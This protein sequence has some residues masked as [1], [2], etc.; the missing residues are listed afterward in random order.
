MRPT[1]SDRPTASGRRPDDVPWDI[2]CLPMPPETR[3]RLFERAALSAAD[4]G[5]VLRVTAGRILA[6]HDEQETARLGRPAVRAWACCADPLPA[7]DL[8]A[9]SAALVERGASFAALSAW[10]PLPA[11]EGFIDTGASVYAV[12]EDVRSGHAGR[13]AVEV[14]TLGQLPEEWISKILKHVSA[15]RWLDRHAKDPRM[16]EGLVRR[17]RLEWL[18]Q[19][20]RGGDGFLMSALV[21]GGELGAYVFVPIDRSRCESGGPVVAGLNGL[22]GSLYEGRWLVRAAIVEGLRL[23]KSMW[24]VAVLQYQPEN[25]PIARIAQRTLAAK[26]STR[27]DAHWYG[28]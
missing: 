24:D 9:F 22:S 13:A 12:I 26:F 11:C 18:E 20:L 2:P 19:Q 5:F 14:H 23:T 10:L 25:L 4:K 21:E 7:Q 15:A 28:R 3:R 1:E 8:R 17:R 16:D 27:F 6:W